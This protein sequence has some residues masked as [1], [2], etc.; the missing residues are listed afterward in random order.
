MCAFA[1]KASMMQDSGAVVVVVVNL[2]R[3]DDNET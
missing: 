3:D 1:A 2:D